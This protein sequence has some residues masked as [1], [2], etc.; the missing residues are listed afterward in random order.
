M[1]K[2]VNALH[3]AE[4][5]ISTKPYDPLKHRIRTFDRDF[6]VWEKSVE[7]VEYGMQQ[8]VKERICGIETTHGVLLVLKR[9]DRLGL[10]CLCMDHRYLDVAKMLEKEIE[11]I[12]DM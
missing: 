4:R 11:S 6:E 5:V 7:D 2:F 9:F 1:E 8:F 3:E 12:K 10:D